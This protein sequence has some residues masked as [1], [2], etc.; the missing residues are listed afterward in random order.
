M[1][2][3]HDIY[4][5]HE[6]WSDALQHATDQNLVD[7]ADTARRA[8]ASGGDLVIEGDPEIPVDDRRFSSQEEFDVYLGE[9]NAAR[10]SLGKSPI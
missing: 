6:T 3:P 4:I 1:S 2:I 9:I 8:I 7:I 10:Q 5:D